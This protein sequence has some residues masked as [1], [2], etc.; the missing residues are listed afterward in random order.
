MTKKVNSSLRANGGETHTLKIRICVW[1]NKNKKA[2][3]TSDCL[4]SCLWYITEF[5]EVRL[6]FSGPLLSTSGA[7]IV[8]MAEAPCHH[9]PVLMGRHLVWCRGILGLLT[10]LHRFLFFFFFSEEVQKEEWAAVAKYCGGV[11]LNSPERRHSVYWTASRKATL[12][13]AAIRTP[14]VRSWTLTHTIISKEGRRWLR[15]QGRTQWWS[16]TSKADSPSLSVR[17]AAGRTQ[18]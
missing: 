1:K 9:E 7:L 4:L 17:W 12:R 6:T 8:S 13:K 15:Q 2:L 16:L 10:P 5:S 14:C 3:S 18:G 11:H